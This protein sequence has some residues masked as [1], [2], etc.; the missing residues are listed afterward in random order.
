M[1]KY[2]SDRGGGEG[3]PVPKTYAHKAGYLP[4]FVLACNH[5]LLLNNLMVLR[6]TEFNCCLLAFFHLHSERDTYRC[7]GY[8]EQTKKI[9]FLR[10]IFIVSIPKAKFENL[11]IFEPAY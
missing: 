3:G 11:K 4:E 10:N 1:V 9:S 8:G 5:P 2:Y 7:G 6:F